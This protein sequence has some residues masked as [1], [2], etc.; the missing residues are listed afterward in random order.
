MRI[1][2]QYWNISIPSTL[3]YFIWKIQNSGKS[4]VD[5]GTGWYRNYI[6]WYQ[7]E[8]DK[9][10]NGIISYIYLHFD[11]QL[12]AGRAELLGEYPVNTIHAWEEKIP[13]K[14]ECKFSQNQTTFA[15]DNKCTSI[16]IVGHC[17]D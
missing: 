4:K 15:N 17:N 3:C 9:K 11:L 16:N 2:Y 13:W 5:F 12:D 7:K 6:W 1:I 14:G 8:K 10:Y